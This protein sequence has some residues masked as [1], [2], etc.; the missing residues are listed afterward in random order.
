VSA[1][2]EALTKNK[3]PSR[4]ELR[5]VRRRNRKGLIKRQGKLGRVSTVLTAVIV[6]AALIFGV[7]LEQVVLA[8]SAF[9]LADL[10]GQLLEAESDHE[11]LLLESAKLDSAA[12]IERFARSSLGMVDPP[13]GGVEYLVADVPASAATK[14]ATFTE[15]RG[16]KVRS[17]VGGL[18]TATGSTSSYVEGAP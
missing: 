12:R 15:R 9:K 2:V 3:S 6:C 17:D 16:K 18:Q 11:E 7:L 13:P 5:L 8:Q 1:R 10:R 4:A 14:W